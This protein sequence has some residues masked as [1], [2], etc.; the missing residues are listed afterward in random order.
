[1][2]R[3]R[4][5]VL[6]VAGCAAAVGALLWARER[7]E[8]PG[9]H[10]EHVLEVLPKG[11]PFIL[12]I[13]V[14]AVRRAGWFSV[15]SRAFAGPGTPAVECGYDP[16]ESAEMIG[17]YA[18]AHGDEP[19][20]V[21]LAALGRFDAEQILACAST[22]IRKRRGEPR[23]TPIGSF[24]T[25]RDAH[26]RGGEV[27]VRSGG[28]ILVG[29]ASTLRQLIDATEG[30]TE[31]AV[32]DGDHAALRNAVGADAAV[33]AT[34]VAGPHARD[35][36]ETLG[37]GAPLSGLRA[38][39]ASASIGKEELTVRVR[40]LATDGQAAVRITEWLSDATADLAKHVPRA[41]L[42]TSGSE[43]RGEVRLP[44]ETI[45]SVLKRID[46]GD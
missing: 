44:R 46:E 17:V 42:D 28:P 14:D 39:A 11:V 26:G 35:T 23:R 15:A 5:G 2:E 31:S 45:E 32:T 13:R 3:V 27:A 18:E 6:V 43:V 34:W 8:G 38:A 4:I 12:T 33:V 36:L 29:G 37:L 30:R 10:V 41:H 7:S 25:L 20:D 21:G 16:L 24:L 22:L 9:P 40:L 19:I 1:V